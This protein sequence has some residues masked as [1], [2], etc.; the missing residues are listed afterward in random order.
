MD[1]LQYI[2]MLMPEKAYL[3]N[4]FYSAVGPIIG[5]VLCMSTLYPVAMLIKVLVEEK[6]SRVK[7][8]M[9]IMGLSDFV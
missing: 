2:S 6:E 1:E 9:K 3:V 7:E 8:T 4:R 5:L